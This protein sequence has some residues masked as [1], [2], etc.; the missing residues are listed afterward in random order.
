MLENLSDINLKEQ[1]K[2]NTKLRL[3]TFIVGGL[4]V[5]VLGYFLYIQFIWKSSNEKSKGAYYIGL[6]YADKD[7]TDAA[8]NELKPVVK[9]YDGK[10]GGEVA[11]FVLARQLMAKGQFKQALDELEDVDVEDTYVSAMSLG[12]QGDCQSELT[13]YED[14]VELYVKAAE[15][16]DNELTTPM[17]LFKAGLVSEK[18]K[19]FEKATEYYTSIKDNYPDFGRQKTIEKYIARTSNN[20]KK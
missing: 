2:S 7:S 14:A 9:K 5:L 19:D 1:F 13:K 10:I 12:L 18:L 11:Q 6:N 17:Y 15:I 20:T 16:N 3:T 8:I 4:A